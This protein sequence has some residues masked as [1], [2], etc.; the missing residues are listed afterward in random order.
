MGGEATSWWWVRH[1]PVRGPAGRIYGQTD[2]DCD[3]SDAASFQVLANVLPREAV[4]LVSPLERTRQT[5]AAIA[6]GL[7]RDIEAEIEA[8]FAEQRFGSWEGLN[9]PE[10]QRQDPGA[11]AAF[12]EDPTRH[13]PP[14]GESFATL[15]ARVTTA[16]ERRGRQHAGKTI[17]AIAHGGTIRAAVAH[18][19]GLT[20]EAAM[21]IVVDNLSLTR[22]TLFAERLLHDRGGQWRIETINAP[23]RWIPAAGSC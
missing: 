23:C 21:A 15:M 17:V 1:A 22:L 11:Y 7:C 13:A 3:T 6:A 20:P 14:A 18:A 19:L 4:W 5:F 16:I 10:M 9:W 2:V 12:W 8:D